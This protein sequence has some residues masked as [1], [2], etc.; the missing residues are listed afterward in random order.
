MRLGELAALKL[1]LNRL[2]ARGGNKYYMKAVADC[3]HVFFAQLN[4]AEVEGTACQSHSG[5]R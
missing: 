2:K 5:K 3:V 4:C 1:E